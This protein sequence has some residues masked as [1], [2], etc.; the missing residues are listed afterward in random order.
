MDIAPLQLYS[1][2]LIFAPQTSIIRTTFPSQCEEI[3]PVLPNNPLHWNTTPQTLEGHTGIVTD[4]A[5][6]PNGAL[7]VTASRDTTMRLWDA[8]TGALLRI[9]QD[10]TGPVTCVV[11]SPDSAR[12]A[13]ASEDTTVRLWD[14]SGSLLQ[15]LVLEHDPVQLLRFLPDGK[16]LALASTN[17]SLQLWDTSTGTLQ[18]KTKGYL[19]I[20]DP[21][22]KAFSLDGTQLAA[23]GHQS[24]TTVRIWDTTTGMLLHTLRAESESPSSLAFSPDKMKLVGGSFSHI[25]LWDLATDALLWTTR[26]ND[27]FESHIQF[28]LD[29]SQLAFARSNEVRLYDVATG[30]LV[31]TVKAHIYLVVAL[32]FLPGGTRLAVSAQFW[33]ILLLDTATSR[34]Q[35]KI[36]RH[37]DQVSRM[38]FSWNGMWLATGALDGSV[39]LWDPATGVAVEMV[40]GNMKANAENA[41]RFVG[42]VLDEL[43]KEEYRDLVEAKHLVQ[44]SKF[45]GSMTGVAGRK[46]EAKEKLSWLFPG[47]FE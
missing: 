15:T 32:A 16:Q 22:V 27:W 3:L 34:P 38:E 43:S 12:L 20:T 24:D 10:H 30:T 13:S 6:S 11:V 9:L 19:D 1:S 44:Q 36:Q 4:I 47:Y 26:T 23:K 33:N 18:Q 5:V 37:K 21:A 39:Q 42:A 14:A 2:A 8:A 41:R 29:G 45:A 17:A 28:S 7:L 35:Q 25:M 40:M 31:Q 46:A